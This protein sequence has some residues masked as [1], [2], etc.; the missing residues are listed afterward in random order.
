M[1]RVFLY[2]IL[3]I[4]SFILFVHTKSVAQRTLVHPGLSHKRSDLDRMKYMVQAGKEP[5]KTSFQNLSQNPYASYNYAVQGDP[6]VTRLVEPA[7]L[8]G[9]NY[10]KFKYD[11]LAAYYNSIMWYITGDERHAQ[12]CVAIFNAWVNIT[13]IESNGTKALD[14]GRVIWKMLEGAEIIKNTYPGWSATDIDKFR[15]MLVY[16]GYSTT[17][18]PTAAIDAEDATF[19]WYMYNGDPGR[20]GNQGNFAMRGIMAVGVFMDNE[21]IYDRALRYM[22]GLPHRADDLPYPPG[23]RIVTA[24]PVASSNEYYD[25]YNTVSP[26]TETTIPDYGYNELISNYIW[27]NGQCQESSR[28]QGHAVSGVSNINTMCEIAWSQGDDMYSF[29]DYRPLLGI[30]FGM[31]YNMSLNYTFADQPAPWEPTV[32]NGEFIQRRDRS[33]RWFSK[34]INPWNGGDL[35]RLTRGQSFKFNEVPFLEMALGHFKDRVGLDPNRYKWLKRSFDAST[36][37]YGLEGQGF[38]VDHPGWGGLTFRRAANSPG[39]PV[40]FVNGNPVYKMNMLPGKIEAENFDHFVN[41]GDGKVYH[42]LTPANEG[43]QYR[44][45]EAVDIEVSSEGGYNLTNLEDGE[46]INYTVAVPTSGKYK[47][48][49]RY[50]S[51]AASGFLKIEFDGI[52]KTGQVAVP[53]GSGHSNGAQDWQDMTVTTGFT[54]HAGVQSMRVFISGN[55]NVFALNHFSITYLSALQSQT[56]DFAPLPAKNIGAA[57]FNPGASATSGLPVTYTSSNNSVATIVNNQVHVVG[58]GVTTI[59]AAQSGDDTYSPASGVSQTLTVSGIAAGD[60]VSSGNISWNGGSWNISDGN[61]GVSGTTT[62]APNA[63]S[64]VHILAGHTVTLATTAG[65]IKNLTIQSGGVLLQQTTLTVSGLTTISGEHTMS[66]TF[67]VN[68]FVI[69]ESG[70]LT[71]TTVPAGSVSSLITNKAATITINGRLGAPAGS[72][73]TTVGSGIRIFVNGSGTT[74]FTGAGTV[75]IARFSPNGNNASTQTIIIDINMELRNYAGSSVSSLT[76]QNGSTG[77]GTKVLVINEGKTVKLNGSNGNGAFHG[78]YGTAYGLTAANNTGSSM[79]YNING[80]LDCS[81]AQFNLVTNRQTDANMVTVNVNGVLKLGSSV[82]LFRFRSA[83]KIYVNVADGGLVDGAAVALNLNHVTAGQSVNTSNFTGTTA[84]ANALGGV[85]F[86]GNNPVVGTYT[87]D[88]NGGSGYVTPPSVYFNGGTT[89]NNLSPTYAIGNLTNGVVTSITVISTGAYTVKPTSLE[90]V[91][92]GVPAQW[93]SF[94]GESQSGVI[95]RLVSAGVSTPFWLG[96]G[97]SSYNPL[98]VKPT[99]ETVFTVNIREGNSAPTSVPNANI[100]LNRTWNITPVI[101]SATDLTFGYNNAQG[102]AN[103]NPSYAMRLLHYNAGTSAWETLGG[104]A[105]ADAGTGTDAL[106]TFTGVSAFSPFTI[107][108]DVSVLPVKLVFFNVRKSGGENNGRAVLL[109]WKTSAETNSD[110]FEIER[111]RDGKSWDAIGNIPSSRESSTLVEYSFEDTRP[112][113]SGPANGE[114][115]YRLKMVDQDQTFAYSMI[116]SVSFDADSRT[117]LYPNPVTDKITIQTDNW[118]R[119][120][121]VKIFDLSG[122]L[123][124]NDEKNPSPIVSARNLSDGLYLLYIIRDNQPAEILKVAVVK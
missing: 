79:T 53:F 38:Q 21:I 104:A 59:T 122:K 52:D 30:E 115:L 88:G 105:N 54:L 89:S 103:F 69:T 5:W 39:D 63:N 2:T 20:H 41:D 36:N 66:S 87:F 118:Q 98:T 123:I 83:Q 119:V 44:T 18:E 81:D 78:A 77:A 19:Y 121:Q 86:S 120:T 92:G 107:A 8:P 15:D 50:A 85:T 40:E 26:Y 7:A 17:T 34:K 11:A 94:T 100:T 28:D 25:E 97:A 1:K 112:F 9:Y 72:P 16:P 37:E 43:N 67:T 27:E 101:P 110:H 64:N 74:T 24:A 96:N 116:R 117:V 91:G 82:R 14:A 33:S 32:E 46:W 102:N 22:K 49:A 106:I 80:T 56:I 35:T 108:N 47:L 31:R 84:V 111:S 60:Y 73:V 124:Y 4:S 3:L 70:V 51:S 45:G 90:F 99:S 71:S 68:D 114:N 58:P 113:T 42:D 75:N 65:V 93:F 48:D 95:T 12:K 6:S 109:T 29:L 76:L 55:S 10:E 13:H 61:G 23:P 62:T 57:D